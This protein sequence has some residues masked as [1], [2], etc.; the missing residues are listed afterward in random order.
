MTSCTPEC[1]A[2]AKATREEFAGARNVTDEFG[3][4]LESLALRKTLRGCAWIS[5]FVCNSRKRM[6]ERR[7][8]PLTTE[9]IEKKK[10]FWTARAKNSGKRSEKFEDDRLQL[11]ESAEKK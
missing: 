2:E 11:H 7:F 1:Q 3:V 9:E 6:E 4:L 10:Y 8:G 5:R